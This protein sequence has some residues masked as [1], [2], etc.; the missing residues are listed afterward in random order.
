MKFQELEE[1][2]CKVQSA[3]EEALASERERGRGLEEKLANERAE[4]SWLVGEKRELEHQLKIVTSE[5]R[6]MASWLLSLLMCLCVCSV[7][8]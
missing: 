7:R 5:V 6:I 8:D 1:K 2:Q 3:L 4:N